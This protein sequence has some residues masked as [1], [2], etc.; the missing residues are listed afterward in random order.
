MQSVFTQFLSKYQPKVDAKLAERWSFDVNLHGEKN[1]KSQIAIAKRTATA[2]E[3][4]AKKFLNIS[5]KQASTLKEAAIAMRILAKELKPV[6]EWAKAYKAYRDSELRRKWSETLENFAVGRWGDTPGLVELEASIV[7]QLCTPTGRLAFGE[8]IVSIGENMGATSDCISSCFERLESGVTIRE[9]LA[10]T[11]LKASFA[12]TNLWT[13]TTSGPF[14]T[15][16][17]ATYER[18]RIHRFPAVFGPKN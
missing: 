10:N 15:C 17:W 11:L 14:L 5:S 1:I 12:R 16:S 7:M 3:N 2:L 6:A 13:S 4:A 8:W 18:Y 9:K